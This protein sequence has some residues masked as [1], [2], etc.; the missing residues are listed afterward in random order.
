MAQAVGIVGS[1]ENQ[2]VIEP[3]P[4]AKKSIYSEINDYKHLRSPLKLRFVGAVGVRKSKLG[5]AVAPLLGRE[6]GRPKGYYAWE[7][8]LIR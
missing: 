7:I 5:G 6:S 4:R 3:L 1:F 2:V 8:K